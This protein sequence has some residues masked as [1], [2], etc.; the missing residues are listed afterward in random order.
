MP[1]LDSKHDDSEVIFNLIEDSYADYD[2]DITQSELMAKIFRFG[3]I[4]D[5]VLRYGESAL[6]IYT[7]T[8]YEEETMA[9]IKEMYDGSIWTYCEENDYK[10]DIDEYDGEY[11]NHDKV[12]IIKNH[13]YFEPKLK[14]YQ[15]YDYTEE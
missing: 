6:S 5:D 7:S 3:D 12:V 9:N 14:L 11:V 4:Q 15:R 8:T 10:T 2:Y 13:V 1:F